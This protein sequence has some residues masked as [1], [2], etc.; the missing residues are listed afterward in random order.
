MA[1]IKYQPES[2]LPARQLRRE[3][4]RSHDRMEYIAESTLLVQAGIGSIHTEG[5]RLMVNAAI[6]SQKLIKDAEAQ[7]VPPA[8]LELMIDRQMQAMLMLSHTAQLGSARLVTLI[9][10]LPSLP[11]QSFLDWLVRFLDNY[12]DL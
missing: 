5:T 6:E 12:P 11:K 10:Q 7:G 2:E 3:L 8:I 4:A 9:Q 1:I